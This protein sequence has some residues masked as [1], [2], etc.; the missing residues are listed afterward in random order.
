MDDTLVS[1]NIIYNS[2]ETYSASGLSTSDLNDVYL[3]PKT[4][5]DKITPMAK[6]LSKDV[7]D[8]LEDAVKA[9]NLRVY[10]TLTLGIFK[11]E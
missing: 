11:H 1:Q 5:G 4:D 2:E 8:V 7:H 3:F 6:T 9:C 10:S